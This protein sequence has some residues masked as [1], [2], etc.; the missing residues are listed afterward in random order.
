M[1]SIKKKNNSSF[2][3][4]KLVKKFKRHIYSLNDFFHTNN[5]HIYKEDFAEIDSKGHVI[6]QCMDIILGAINFK[7]TI[8]QHG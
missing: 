3:I 5:I 8:K 2:L 7:L 6:L 1:D 4:K